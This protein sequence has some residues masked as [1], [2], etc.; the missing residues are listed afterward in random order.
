MAYSAEPFQ[1]S[2]CHFLV[3]GTPSPQS[4]NTCNMLPLSLHP[5]GSHI[6]DHLFELEISPEGVSI[7]WVPVGVSIEWVPVG[8]SIE[9]VPVGVS[10]EW[11]PVGVSIEWVPVGVSRG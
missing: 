10:I 3:C 7:E 8:V 6:T 1:S 9:W 11:V 4:D 5:V 2:A